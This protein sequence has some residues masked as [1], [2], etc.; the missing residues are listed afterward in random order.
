MK[1][2]IN[3]DSDGFLLDFVKTCRNR[4][5]CAIID[6][7][8]FSSLNVGEMNLTRDTFVTSFKSV[9]EELFRIRPPHASYT[10]VVLAYA[11]E[12]HEYHRHV[13]WYDSDLLIL[14]LVGVLIANGF[15]AYLPNRCTLL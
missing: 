11:L 7:H 6:T 2:P 10:V 14:S 9:C 1:E 3:R 12:L 13:A 8:D 15:E 4:E 5:M